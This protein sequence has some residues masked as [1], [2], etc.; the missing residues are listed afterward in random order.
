[1]TSPRRGTT[2]SP[3]NG[4]AKRNA[5]DLA[6]TASVTRMSFCA[7]T[8]G[9]ISRAASRGAFSRSVE[10]IA[11][12]HPIEVLVDEARGIGTRRVEAGEGLHVRERE[13][14]CAAHRMQ[15]PAQQAIHHDR[16]ANLV[17]VRKRVHEDV[18]A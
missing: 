2:S 1:M 16:A 11:G 15:P 7:G 4:F 18:R 14:E 5:G 6:M 3:L 13:R 9:S 10:D 17:A 12:P 8:A